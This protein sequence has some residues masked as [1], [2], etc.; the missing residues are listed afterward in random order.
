VRG[1]SDASA[2]CATTLSMPPS[3]WNSRTNCLPCVHTDRM[4]PK[5]R[6]NLGRHSGGKRSCD[7]QTTG[8]NPSPAKRGS[9]ASEKEQSDKSE[10]EADLTSPP[11]AKGGSAETPVTEGRELLEQL[12]SAAAVVDDPA[13][14]LQHLRDLKAEQARL[15]REAMSARDYWKEQ[16][17]TARQQAR[18]AEEELAKYKEAFESALREIR[19]RQADDAA[20]TSERPARRR[21]AKEHRGAAWTWPLWMVQLILELLVN[22]VP[23]ASI[24]ACIR[25]HAELSGEPAEDVDVPCFDFCKG[26]RSVLRV[27]IETLTA[28][29]LATLANEARKESVSESAYRLLP[30]WWN[31]R[32]AHFEGA[33]RLDVQVPPT[34]LG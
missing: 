32:G 28:C 9:A 20:A 22:G 26:M 5:R 12:L 11:P 29:R 8:N 24:P 17:E 15:K 16:A 18:D 6:S 23:P 27:L 13:E 31:P 25:S 21:Y 2:A 1:P 10:D 33:W 34:P 19:A 3:S 14:Q 30:S 4:P 7:R